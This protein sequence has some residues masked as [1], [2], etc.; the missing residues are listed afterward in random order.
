MRHEIGLSWSVT[1]DAVISNIKRDKSS[2]C[3]KNDGRRYIRDVRS[4]NNPRPSPRPYAIMETLAAPC[5]D[6]TSSSTGFS[7]S[8]VCKLS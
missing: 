8:E 1:P 4:T 7:M 6:S 5:V 2:A 3:D